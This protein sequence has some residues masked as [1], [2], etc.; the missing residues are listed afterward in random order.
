MRAPLT[1]VPDIHWLAAG[2][3][4]EEQGYRVRRPGGT[5]DHLL[6]LTVGGRGRFGSADGDLVAE[7]GTVTL[8]SP[9]TPHDYGVE[10]ELESWEISYCHFHPRP[11]WRVLLDWPE[12]RAGIGQLHVLGTVGDR[13][14][15][16]LRTAG[17]YSLSQQPRAEMFGMNA[18]ESAL[19]WCDTQNP[20]ARRL[21]GRILRVLEHL[22]QHVAEPVTLA[23]LA[24]VASLSPSR[25]SHLFAEQLGVP[26]LT[27]LEHQRMALARQLLDLTT[28]PIADVA[29]SV[30]FTDPLYFS[31]RFRRLVGSS[32]TEYRARG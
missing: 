4:S 12:V 15:E 3:L 9:H 8:I 6:I 29:H 13:V 17:Y 20:R 10:A 30:G 28:R 23:G 24:G 2:S 19:L 7:P 11:E 22:D 31:T 27:Y 18:L 5:T 25:F 16:Q 26:P 32:P 1:F 21:D 14:R